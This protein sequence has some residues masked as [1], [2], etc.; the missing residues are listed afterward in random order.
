VK[1]TPGVTGFV[2]NAHNPTPLRF[3]E[4]FEMLK[5]TVQVAEAPAPKGPAATT[6][7]A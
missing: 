3:D 1:H 7:G 2:G 5:S 6:G 4:A